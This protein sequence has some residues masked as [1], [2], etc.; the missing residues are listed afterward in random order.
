M[1]RI[2]FPRKVSGSFTVEASFTAPLV[3]FLIIAMLYLILFLHDSAVLQTYP[4]R[5]CEDTLMG[6]FYE[7]YTPAL[8]R[9]QAAASIQEACVMMPDPSAGASLE[10]SFFQDIGSYINC[11][12]TARGNC[13]GSLTAGIAGAAEFMGGA[14]KFRGRCSTTTVD[15]TSDWYKYHLVQT[16]KSK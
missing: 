10:G 6:K 15:Y 3:T 9:Q 14:L 8:S 4:L 1:R 5:S 11:S 2:A 7:K 12:V 16:L 13:S